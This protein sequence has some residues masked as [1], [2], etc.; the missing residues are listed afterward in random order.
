MIYRTKRAQLILAGM[1]VTF[2]AMRLFLYFAPNADLNAGRYN[3]HHFFTGVIVMSI[4][5]ILLGAFED[6]GRIL[7]MAATGFGVGLGLTLDEWVYL[8]ATDGSNASYWL[9]VSVWSSIIAIGL[10][11]AFILAVSFGHRRQ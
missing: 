11:G 8:I 1:I 7:S 5:G 9:P 10:A 6:G 2:V 3:I 4:T